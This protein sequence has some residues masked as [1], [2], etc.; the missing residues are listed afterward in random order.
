MRTPHIIR[1]EAAVLKNGYKDIQEF[2]R[3]HIYK[4]NSFVSLKKV[5][6]E[7]FGIQVSKT[8][9][10]T[11]LRK[12][13][14]LNFN[15]ST[16][17]HFK[18]KSVI[19][20][21]RGNV[22]ASIVN[23]VHDRIKRGYTLAKIAED[24]GSYPKNI[25]RDL[26]KF[27]VD[28]SGNTIFPDKVRFGIRKTPDYVRWLKRA[29]KFGFDSV[30]DCIEYLIVEKGLSIRKASFAMGTTPI[31]LERRIKHCEYLNKIIGEE[32]KRRKENGNHTI[33]G[34]NV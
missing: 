32:I 23:F 20:S 7:R 8:W 19:N 12:Y 1:L 28:L 25:W 31:R 14:P 18:R 33:S 11:Y 24:L 34:T 29:N 30:V 26:R 16:A 6:L 17:G 10:N 3:E 2:V 15:R 5:I 4:G 9:L 21:G 27:P 22:S 13:A